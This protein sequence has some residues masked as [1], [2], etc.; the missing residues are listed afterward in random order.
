M[1]FPARPTDQSG[2]GG[3]F[4][5]YTPCIYVYI[6]ILDTL[7]YVHTC[8]QHVIII[9]NLYIYAHHQNISGLV[10]LFFQH[11]IAPSILRLGLVASMQECSRQTDTEWRW[12]LHCHVP[13]CIS[14][15]NLSKECRVQVP[16]SL[17]WWQKWWHLYVCLLH[18]YQH[19]N[20]KWKDYIT[21]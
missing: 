18:I 8:V 2:N 15:S 5:N 12:S 11:H 16:P 3:K 6:Y 1:L 9:Y 21:I 17:G 7:Y 4:A 13:I 10:W 14:I 20:M 19:F